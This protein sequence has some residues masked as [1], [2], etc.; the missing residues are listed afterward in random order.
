M[1]LYEGIM[2]QII[3]HEVISCMETADRTALIHDAAYQ[4]LCRIHEILDDKTLDDPE[5]FQRIERIVSVFESLGCT[6]SRHEH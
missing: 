4:A 6:T 2:Q 3:A 1:S 5:C